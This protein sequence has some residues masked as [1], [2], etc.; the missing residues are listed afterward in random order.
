MERYKAL[1]LDTSVIMK[2]Y[3]EEEDSDKALEI[4]DKCIRGE[5]QL[6]APDLVLY[7]M[8]NA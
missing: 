3:K 8:V 2:W 1:V 6:S 5:I 4:R 7:E